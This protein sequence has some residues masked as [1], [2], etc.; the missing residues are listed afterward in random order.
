MSADSSQIC[1]IGHIDRRGRARRMLTG[2]L[3]AAAALVLLVVTPPGPWRF[4]LFLPFAG[5]SLGLLQAA[6]R[7]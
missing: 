4:A 1:I 2:L 5:A 3:S 7:T 6:E